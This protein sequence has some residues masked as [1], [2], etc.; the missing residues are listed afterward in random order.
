MK[1][2]GHFTDDELLNSLYGI[3]PADN[4]LDD[5]ADC[6]SRLAAMQSN[7]EAIERAASIDNRIT[8]EF[9]AAQRRAIYRRLDQPL[10][11][12]NSVAIR[13]WAAGLTT[14]C[15]LSGS[16]FLYEQNREMKMAQERASD[17]QLAQEVAAMANDTDVSAMA[18]LHGL[19]E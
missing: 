1:M 7:R 11:W 19:F 16:I 13:R 14:A 6:R 17:A 9:L 15:V 2:S 4:H 3:D 5:C 8:V 18:P 10:R 12:W